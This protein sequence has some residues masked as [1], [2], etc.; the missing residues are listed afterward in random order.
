MRKGQ[1]GLWGYGCSGARK[2]IAAFLGT[3]QVMKTGGGSEGSEYMGADVV[4]LNLAGLHPL[5]C[6]RFG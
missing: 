3:A 6:T 4:T 2:H 1:G 5:S